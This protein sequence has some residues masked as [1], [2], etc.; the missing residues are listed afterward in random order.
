MKWGR[1]TSENCDQENAI[2]NPSS[3]SQSKKKN[4]REED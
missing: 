3:G 1:E 4:D 2:K